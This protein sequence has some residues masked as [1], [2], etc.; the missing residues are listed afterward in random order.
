MILDKVI[1][2]A[3]VLSHEALTLIRFFC[4]QLETTQLNQQEFL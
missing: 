1:V 2:I 3:A 4:T